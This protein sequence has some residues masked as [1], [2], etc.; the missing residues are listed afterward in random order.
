RT[1]AVRGTP[2]ERWRL[3][4]FSGGLALLL[5]VLA[6]PV[7]ALGEEQFL[8][9][10]MT[11]HIV[12]GDLAPLLIVAGLTGP[13]LRPLLALPVIGRL[14]VLGLAL[15]ALP[16]WAFNLSCWRRAVVSAAGVHDDARRA[17]CC[18]S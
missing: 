12:I 6:S 4:C 16:L 8:F 15:V 1:L 10:H 13:I 2:V 9:M 7:D 11:Q 5:F 14:R 17:S 3:W 18:R